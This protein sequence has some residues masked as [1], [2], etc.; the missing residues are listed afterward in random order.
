[1]R[2][3][4]VARILISGLLLGVV[5]P[6]AWAE[7]AAHSSGGAAGSSN[8]NAASAAGGKASA[9]QQGSGG[10][11]ASG[12][13]GASG[14]GAG[15]GG[16]APMASRERGHGSA[17]ENG[18]GK[19]DDAHTGNPI[20][21]R[22]AEPPRGNS[23]SPLHT[24]PWK[25]AARNAIPT[26]AALATPRTFHLRHPSSNGGIA[27]TT[28]NAIG[29]MHNNQSGSVIAPGHTVIGVGNHN[30]YPGL[31]NWSGNS[32]GGASEKIGG[33]NAGQGYIASAPRAPGA[34]TANRTTVN[35]TGMARVGTGPSTLGGPAKAAGINGTSIR[36]KH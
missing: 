10:E 2:M 13:S 4:L 35:G 20:D 28:R 14:G 17:V 30:G 15:G 32:A 33:S 29:A 24:N 25:P 23:P 27:D 16:G 8:S 34:A 18:G 26:G 21:T 9:P 11:R 6:A 7:E 12:G 19:S 31:R 5:M 36:P 22:I 1:M 3:G